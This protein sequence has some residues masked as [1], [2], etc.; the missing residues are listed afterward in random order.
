MRRRSQA[1]AH[2]ALGTV[3]VGHGRAKF[4]RC[5]NDSSVYG[6]NGCS[7][8]RRSGTERFFQLTS[9]RN[10]C[11]EQTIGRGQFVRIAVSLDADTNWN[12]AVQQDINLNARCFQDV[13]IVDR[14]AV[15]QP[16]LQFAEKQADRGVDAR[17]DQIP[18]SVLDGINLLEQ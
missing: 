16:G 11:N 7:L 10:G 3:T 4:F 9:G 5:A 13:P 1:Q 14:H 17:D 12:A 15:H 8:L 18:S 2:H 6:E